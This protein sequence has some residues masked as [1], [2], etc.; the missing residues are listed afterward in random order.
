MGD[1]G[2]PSLTNVLG[3]YGKALLAV[4]DQRLRLITNLE[5][6]LYVFL[7]MRIMQYSE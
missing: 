1:T 4:E 6:N 3:E 5:R 2:H 7:S